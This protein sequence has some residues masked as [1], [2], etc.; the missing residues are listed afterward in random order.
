MAYA[1]TLFKH[2]ISLAALERALGVS[3]GGEK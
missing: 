3:V 1:Q 2:A